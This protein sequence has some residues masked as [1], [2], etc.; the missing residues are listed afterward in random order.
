MLFFGALSSNRATGLGLN[1]LNL[2]FLG[3]IKEIFFSH[4]LPIHNQKLDG[5]ENQ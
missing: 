2:A 5:I 3:S 4:L 1:Q